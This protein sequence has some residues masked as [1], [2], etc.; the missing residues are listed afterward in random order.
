MLEE[1]ILAG[2]T[3]AEALEVTAIRDELQAMSRDNECRDEHR[4]CYM[5]PHHQR[6]RELGKRL[7]RIGG[8]SLM[9]LI[10][11]SIGFDNPGDARELDVAWHGIGMWE[12]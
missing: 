3:T 8:F 2:L 6:T 5:G 9:L 10:F 12:G 7:H 11:D 4:C 1:Q